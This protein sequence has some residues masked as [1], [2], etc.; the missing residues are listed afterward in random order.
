MVSVEDVEK[1][2]TFCK[3]L[4]VPIIGVVENMSGYVCPH[5]SECSNIFSSGGGE[6]LALSHELPFL[7]KLPICPSVARLLEGKRRDVDVEGTL[8]EK[9]MKTELFPLF[10]EMVKLIINHNQ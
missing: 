1:E 7:G 6:Q 3:T 9:Y 8:I 4:N 5:C 10:Q 2:I